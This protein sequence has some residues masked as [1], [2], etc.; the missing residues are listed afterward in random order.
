MDFSIGRGAT[1][2]RQGLFHF[3]AIGGPD[4]TVY[5]V[6]QTQVFKHNWQHGTWHG[7]V[8]L[9]QQ[10]RALANVLT[11]CTRGMMRNWLRKT[12]RIPIPPQVR[13]YYRKVE[14]SRET[15]FS[16]SGPLRLKQ[17]VSRHAVRHP[18]RDMWNVL[19]N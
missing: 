11:N 3:F 10:Y 8:G 16:R 7:V 19:G 5:K 13:E 18:D 1:D 15:T 12:D 17:T 6:N 2:D 9:N 4:S 14:P